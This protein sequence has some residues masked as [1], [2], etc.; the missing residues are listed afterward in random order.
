MTV[1]FLGCGSRDEKCMVLD[2]FGVEL[3]GFGRDEFR[4]ESRGRYLRRC[5]VFCFCG[6]ISE[7]GRLSSSE[8]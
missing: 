3:L 8:V 4:E 1:V 7:I 5:L 2:V 6:R